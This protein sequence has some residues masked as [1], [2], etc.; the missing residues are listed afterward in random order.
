MK[1]LKYLIDLTTVIGEATMWVLKQEQNK[2]K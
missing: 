1:E 2:G